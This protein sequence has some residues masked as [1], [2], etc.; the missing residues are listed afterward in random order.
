M[1]K[2]LLAVALL[3]LSLVAGGALAEPKPVIGA[4]IGI[5]YFMFIVY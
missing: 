2:G 5:V 1:K 3:G 4:L